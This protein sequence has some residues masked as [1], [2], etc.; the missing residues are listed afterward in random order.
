MSAPLNDVVLITDVI[1]GQGWRG[2]G[3]IIGPH[4]ILTASHLLWDQ[5]LGQGAS[6][7]SVYPGY[8]PGNAPISG[9]EAWHFNTV[10]DSGH[11]MT[12]A[13][14]ASDFGII[15]VAADLS[16]FGSF[17][18]LTDFEG[19]TA[20]LTGYPAS[21]GVAQNDVIGTVQ[22]DQ[23]FDVLDYETITASPGNSGGPVW[24]DEGT[25][26]NPNPEVVGIVSTTGWA[27][28]LTPADLQQI[29]AWENQDSFLWNTSVAQTTDT[30]DAHGN[31]ATQTTRGTDGNTYYTDFN[32]QHAQNWQ[33]AV[34]T[35]DP[36]GS[37]AFTTIKQNDNTEL[38]TSYDPHGVHGW[39][40]AISGY[41]AAGA[42]DHVTVQNL[43]GT[44]QY[45]VYD[46][47]GNFSAYTIYDYD[48]ANRL[49]NSV[50]HDSGTLIV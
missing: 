16:A 25:P 47:P 28:Q 31:V 17:G 4:T 10:D 42:I 41:N 19:G 45:T 15:D 24:V 6:Q 20:H 13:A 36:Q 32:L 5:D 14:S 37:L 27:A 21:A 11:V 7:V 46:H 35:Y 48:A 9:Q 3:V 39:K 1:D 30:Y 34:T 33:Y 38:V 22:A 43:D 44:Q 23:R 2:S 29:Q 12:Q 26:S 8:E 18:V 40:D 50:H 49:V